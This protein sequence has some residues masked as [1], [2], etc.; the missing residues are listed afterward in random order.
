M[1]SLVQRVRAFLSSPQGRTMV[2]KGRRELS[3]PATQQKLRR[4]MARF[5]G[6]R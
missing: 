2:D 5:S 3:K 6:R 4:I 1:A